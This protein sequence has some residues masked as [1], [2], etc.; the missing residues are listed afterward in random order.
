MA[1]NEII[2]SGQNDKTL[3]ENNNA[4]SYTQS[5]SWSIAFF[6]AVLDNCPHR[7]CRRI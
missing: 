5:L 1:E 3:L 2:Q 6:D 7:I 4:Q